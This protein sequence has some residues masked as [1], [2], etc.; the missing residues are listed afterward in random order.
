MARVENSHDWEM[1]K[2]NIQPVKVGRKVSRLGSG[3]APQ[4]LQEMERF[5]DCL[6]Y[7]SIIQS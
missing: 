4:N 7:S 1:T 3:V 2:E 5:V 6:S